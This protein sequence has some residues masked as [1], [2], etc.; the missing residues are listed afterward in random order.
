MMLLATLII[1][2]I[3]VLTTILIHYQTLFLLARKLPKLRLIHHYRVL[4][5]VIV[6]VLAHI[7]EIWLFAIGYYLMIHTGDFG[8]LSGNINLSLLDCSYFS[9]TTYTTLGY[10]DIEPSGYLRFLSGLE[11][12]AGLVMITWSASFVF[13]EMQKYWPK[14]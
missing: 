5:A 9:F 14:R 11:S 4:L 12:L 6:I 1:N 13:L 2:S 3:I 10:G 7:I 8:T